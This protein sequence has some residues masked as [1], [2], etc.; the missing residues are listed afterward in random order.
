MAAPSVQGTPLIA[1]CARVIAHLRDVLRAIR[2]AP[3]RKP[4]ISSP[5]TAISGKTFAI[6]PAMTAPD[7]TFSTPTLAELRS[8]DAR[9]SE[10]AWAAAYPPLW[11]ATAGLLAAHLLVGA[12]YEHDREDIAARSLGELVR[13]VVEGRPESFNQLSS[14]DDLQGMALQIVRARTKDYFRHRGRRPEDPTAELPEPSHPSGEPGTQLSREEFDNLIARLPPPQPEIFRLHYVQ[15]HTAE[16]IATQTGMPRNTVLSHLFRGKKTLR[17][18][19]E[20]LFSEAASRDS[21]SAD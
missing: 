9:V 4:R 17:T 10:R 7:A 18:W 11:K 16:E 6:L 5:L 19:L 13:G 15:G 12:Q 2:P 14:F 8:T 3:R 21:R 1:R 20:A